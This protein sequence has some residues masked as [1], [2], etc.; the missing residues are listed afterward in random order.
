[1][2]LFPSFAWLL[3]SACAA[4]ACAAPREGN[5]PKPFDTQTRVPWITSRVAGTPDPPLPFRLVRAFE[6]LPLKQPLFLTHEPDSRRLLVIEQAGKILSFAAQ[7]EVASS[8]LFLE[9]DEDT[10]SLTF[11]PR[12]ADNHFVYVFS[13]GPRDGPKKRNR[14]ARYKVLPA[15]APRCDPASLRVILE[16]ESNGHN[17]GDLAFGPDGCLYVSAGDGTSDS[18]TNL[19]GQDLSD[20]VSSIL[21]LD[22]HPSDEGRG[23]SIP[24]DNPFVHT[25]GARGEIWAYGLR[26]PWRISFDR[27]TGRLWVGDVGQDWREMVH[28]ITRGGNYGWSVEEGGLPFHPLRTRGPTPIVPPVM[29]HPH[30]EARSLTGGHVYYGDKF[31]EL[32]GAY[33]YGDFATGKVWGLRYDGQRVSW[34]RELADTALQIVSFGADAAGELYVVDYLGGIYEL[35]AH[36]APA[37]DTPF[38]RRLSETGLFASVPTHEP[39]AGVIPYSVNSPLWSDGAKKERFIAIPDSEQIQFTDSR[40]WNF[41]D[42]AVLVKTFSFE[43]GPGEPASHQRIETRLLVRQQGEWTGYSYQWND[44]QTDAELVPAEG[45]DRTF[46]RPDAP[47][48]NDQPIAWRYPSRAECMVCHTR[49]ANYVLGLSTAQMNRTHRYG[50]VEENQLA[51]LE[52]LGVFRDPLPRRPAE[53]VALV[54][55]LDGGAPLESRA[56]SYLHGNCSYCHVSAGGGNAR[57]E[58]E[59]A[60]P[61]DKMNLIGEKPLHDRFGIDEALL[62]VPGVP[63]RSLV[64]ARLRRTERGRMPP[65]GTS[66]VD[67]DAVRLLQEWIARMPVAN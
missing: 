41:S 59:S 42:G 63:E 11:D 1:M 8:E 34:H 33:V 29:S 6:R 13:N 4:V 10:Y 2:R 35:A 14:I 31:P 43:R 15:P 60:T 64:L 57:L 37:S 24:G 46:T 55:P 52:R 67:A 16:F 12:Y 49:A 54:D 38:P 66:V 39:A 36:V 65:L 17:G 23:Y 20:L 56:R 53:M 3:A 32:R 19:T 18:D 50:A 27:D 48:G 21:R 5:E 47:P 45:R 58:L 30:S 25:A 22:V 28:L 40:G 7:A 9:V 51:V 26:N 62:L 61:L 44:A